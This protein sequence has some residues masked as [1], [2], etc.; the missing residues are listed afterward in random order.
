MT[1]FACAGCGGV[2]TAPVS[3]VALPVHAQQTY[4]HE[5]L[6][7]LMEPGTY[8]VNPE[9]SG[10]P[11]RPW[12]E[13][14]ADEAETCGVY[15]PVHSLSFGPRGAVVVAPGD[16]RGT[17]LIPGR[18]DGYCLGLDGRD[19]PNLACARCGLAVATRIDDCSFW[20]AV[21]L[22]PRAVR[23]L[24]GDGSARRV[25]A[26]ETLRQERPGLPPVE[27]SG[28]WSPLWEAAVAA[29]VARLL[30]VSAG[31]PVAVPDGPVAETFRRTLGTLLP[32]GPSAMNLALAGPGLS[33]APTDIALV[34]QHP[35]TGETW[36][37]AGAAHVVPLVADVW[38]YLAFHHDRRP[39]PGAL[40]GGIRRDDPPPPLP[41]EPFRP[42]WGVFLY[43]LARLLEVR[44]PRLRAIYDRVRDNPYAH[45]F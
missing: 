13:V 10:P 44:Q 23:R 22:D 20:Q 34:P 27:Q 18:C 12:A 45:P 2:L 24:S 30:A 7:A 3:Q 6:A 9:S 29:A 38:M 31:T 33:T 4:G 39:V 21:W 19:G 14:G 41:Y 11:W 5:L 25:L 28:A 36:P 15:A 42:D 17:V 16:V 40:P 26:W 35:Q 37:H 8:A 32:P 43:T 1:V